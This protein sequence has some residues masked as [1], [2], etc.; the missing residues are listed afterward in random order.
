M[1]TGLEHVHDTDRAVPQVSE[2]VAE[3]EPLHRAYETERLAL[4]GLAQRP[5][6]PQSQAL[7]RRARAEDPLGG[8]AVDPAT[9]QRLAN[10]TGGRSL[11]PEVR[12]PLESVFRADFSGVNVHTDDNAA[13][14]ARDVQATAFTHGNN[15]FFSAGSYDPATTRGQHLLAHELTHVVQQQQGRGGAAGPAGGPVIGHADDPVEAEAERTAHDVV[16][17]LHRQAAACGHADHS[18]HDHG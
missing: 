4:P 1:Q 12:Q 3:P 2:S 6:R 11:N 7:R 5:A 8:T 14:L 10:P 13:Q 17:S 15:I 16:G 18:D 9:A